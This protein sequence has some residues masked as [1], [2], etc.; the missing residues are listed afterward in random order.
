MQKLPD[1]KLKIIL[2][3][4]KKLNDNVKNEEVKLLE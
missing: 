3:M 4:F 1:R 2:I